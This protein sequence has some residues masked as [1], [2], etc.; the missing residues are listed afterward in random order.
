[1]GKLA[2]IGAGGHGRVVAD[3]A[4]ASGWDIIEFFDDYWPQ[5]TQNVIWDVV[6]NLN[7]L[8]ETI[9][10][11]DGL[12]VA[13]GNNNIRLKEMKKLD[14]LNPPWVSIIH[15][16]AVLSPNIEIGFGVVIFAGAIVNIMTKIGNGVIINT[17][18]TVDHD[19][20]LSDGVHICP[21]V[22]LA[23]GVLVGQTTWIG[24]GTVVKEKIKIGDNVMIGAGSVIVNDF[25]DNQLVYGA[26]ALTQG[27]WNA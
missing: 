7:S 21:G 24:I 14:Y 12:V 10:Q 13:I 20:V 2:I 8:K 1:M 6:G 19:C 15:P 16:K 9:D 17:G 3:A 25:A 27:V 26:P 11:Y 4:A 22:H 18:A 23:G 5:K